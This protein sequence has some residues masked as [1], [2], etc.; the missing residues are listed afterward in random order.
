MK[1]SQIAEPS[2]AKAY[3]ASKDPKRKAKSPDPRWK[4]EFWPILNKKD[5]TEG[6]RCSKQMHGGIRRLKM[7]LTRDAV[8]KG[9]RKTY[10]PLDDE[11]DDDG[12]HEAPSNETSTTASHTVESSAV[13]SKRKRMT[14]HFIVPQLKP[15]QT[16][17]FKLRKT[18]EEV[19][20]KR[21]SKG[22]SQTTLEYS[23]KIE[24]EKD[25]VKTYISNFF[26]E[27]GIPFNA[28]HFR[29][30][31]IMIESI[32]QF[33]PGLQPPSY[34][35]LQVPL[36]EKAK[37]DTDKLREKHKKSWKLYGCTLMS[38]GWSNKSGIH[39]INFLVNSQEWTFFL[40]LIF[41]VVTD[42]DAKFKATGDLML[43]DIVK[44]KDFHVS[45]THGRN[46]TFIYR[47]GRLVNAMREM[48]LGRYIVRPGATRF[49]THFLHY[50][51]YTKNKDALRKL[52]CS[53]EGFDSKLATT[54]AGGKVHDV[55]LS[56][57]FWNNV[58]D[59]IRASHPLLVVLR[60]VDG[61]ETSALAK[62]YVAMD[63]DKKKIKDALDK[64]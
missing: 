13:S 28:S 8:G 7:H 12:N 50:R 64:K 30:Y 6:T 4:Y 62:I 60:I 14:T 61:D 57:R 38:D 32:G 48:T 34:H 29:S 11:D 23:T 46:I 17:A 63:F 18:P 27:N 51:V 10:V 45:I 25:R 58:E 36:L 40:K 53:K 24:E 33:G 59:C 19:V 43:E 49:T 47:L 42:N 26:H 54:S 20:E 56:T 1:S 16:I 22:P 41:Q 37:Q 35:E 44:L 55:V 31:E 5:M 15:T 3:G 39:L 2:S 52:F 21:H 9:T